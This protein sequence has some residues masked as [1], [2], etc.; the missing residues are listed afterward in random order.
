MKRLIA[1]HCRWKKGLIGK[2]VGH[3][4]P[5]RGWPLV[6][7]QALEPATSDPLYVP[8]S[9]SETTEIDDDVMCLDFREGWAPNTRNDFAC[10]EEMERAQHMCAE[11]RKMCKNLNDR[12]Q[13]ACIGYCGFGVSK[14]TSWRRCIPLRNIPLQTFVTA[15]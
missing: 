14:R 2:S 11:V 4:G 7:P 15:F 12:W 13:W 5:K 3:I 8:V 9:D 6:P 1:L 10:V